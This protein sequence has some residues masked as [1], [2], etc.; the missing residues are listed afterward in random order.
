M[1]LCKNVMN[2]TLELVTASGHRYVFTYAT[3]WNL[4][5]A[6]WGG[7]DFSFF[8]LMLSDSEVL[9]SVYLCVF[10]CWGVREMCALVICVCLWVSCCRCENLSS[11][12]S[13]FKWPSDRAPINQKAFLRVLAHHSKNVNFLRSFTVFLYKDDKSPSVLPMLIEIQSV[14]KKCQ[15]F[16]AKSRVLII[17]SK[18][19]TESSRSINP[20]CVPNKI[21]EF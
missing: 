16:S 19:E 15:R 8:I 12:N 11:S 3:Q 1:A 10:L 21:Y 5:L 13:T 20:K 4:P 6:G 14:Y 18:I 7:Y 2:W 17:S 9:Y